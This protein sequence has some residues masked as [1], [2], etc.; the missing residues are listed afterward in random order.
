MRL[1]LLALLIAAAASIGNLRAEETRP[2]N[3]VF[4]LVDDLGWSD[5]GYNDSKV[6]ETPNVDRLASQGMVLSNFYSG[7]PVVCFT[8]PNT[9]LASGSM[10][11]ATS[12]TQLS[13]DSSQVAYL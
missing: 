13:S 8:T 1:P 2:P 5:V 6:Y 4:I 9:I 12:G 11:P 3:V 10:F 7:G